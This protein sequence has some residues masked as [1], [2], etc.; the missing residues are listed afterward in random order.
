M[1]YHN[2]IN[3]HNEQNIYNIDEFHHYYDL[4]KYVS[5]PPMSGS[6]ILIIYNKNLYIGKLP[7]LSVS[8]DN[9]SVIDLNDNVLRSF[10]IF[11][12]KVKLLHFTLS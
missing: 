11:S 9:L 12:I 5:D 3:N 6:K 1:D 7:D 8:G 4:F 2:D 10:D